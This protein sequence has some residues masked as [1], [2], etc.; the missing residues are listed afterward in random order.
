MI[1]TLALNPSINKLAVVDGLDINKTNFVQ[2]YRMNLGES[3]IYT[4][5]TIRLLQGEAYVL[6]FVG[7]IGGRY[8]KNFMEKN[9]IRSD[10]VWNDYESKSIYKIIDSVN[11]TETTLLDDG[12]EIDE[13]DKK[14]FK[15]KL[16]N[17]LKYCKVIVISGELP[18]GSNF[19]LIEEVIKMSKKINKKIILALS[20]EALRK[21]LELKPYGIKI[22][23][24]DLQEL[25]IEETEN[26]LEKLHEILLNYHLHYLVYD[27]GEE[28][29]Y[30]FSKNKICKVYYPKDIE[31]LD[32]LGSSESILGALAVGIERKY[33]QERISKLMMAVSISVKKTEY[34]DICTRKDIDYF[35][36]KVKIYEIMN[37][38]KGWKKIQ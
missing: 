11:G 15:H 34:P 1:I 3:P 37:K 18:K 7:G 27:S 8:I 19:E 36:N 6:G 5:Y 35:K 17:Q 13:Q 9:R 28:G 23:N 14:N 12:I 32:E 38:S 4:A 26:K 25:G 29:I 20:G 16:Q 31:F 21:S 33:E 2:D 30:T 22:C 24:E 10:L